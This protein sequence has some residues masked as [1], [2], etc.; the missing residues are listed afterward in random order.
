MLTPGDLARM[1]S[2][3]AQIIGDNDVAIVLRRGA[4]T[5]AAQTARVE[6]S[7][8]G[9][10]GWRASGNTQEARGRIVLAGSLTFDVQKDDRFTWDGQL[11]RVSFVRPNQ[12][13]G[14]QAEAELV[15]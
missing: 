14:I 9:Q 11:Y 8:G 12:Q 5:L 13:M 4:L 15:Q 1:R 3:L 10:A 7:G 6:R 2:D